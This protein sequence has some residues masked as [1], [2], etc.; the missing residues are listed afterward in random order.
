MKLLYLSLYHSLSFYVS[1]YV[2]LGVMILMPTSLYA[3]DVDTQ[4]PPCKPLSYTKLFHTQQQL[5]YIEKSPSHLH[6]HAPI[7]FALHG[8]GDQAKN[9]AKLYRFFPKEWRVIFVEAPIKYGRGFAWYRFR[10]QQQNEDLILSVELF[11]QLVTQFRQKYPRAAVGV[12]GFSQGGVMS[13]RSVDQAPSLYHAFAS[14][15]GYWMSP[16]VL[17]HSHTTTH[18]QST[19]QSHTTSQSHPAKP[20]LFI[21]H[22]QQDSVVDF[23]EFT[24]AIQVFK[25]KNYQVQSYPF[26]GKHRIPAHSMHALIQFFTKTFTQKRTSHQ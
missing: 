13:L 6:R 18:S 15:S 5:H 12:F 25:K 1:F 22:G 11:N 17:A 14:L 21:T 20:L 19:S 24:E 2:A 7:V 23:K 3:Y 8:L 9:F 26:Q 10:C 4:L 16:K